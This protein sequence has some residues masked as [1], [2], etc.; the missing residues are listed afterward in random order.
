MSQA[1]TFQEDRWFIS[2]IFLVTAFSLFFAALEESESMTLSKPGE[3]PKFPHNLRPLS[4]LF[5]TA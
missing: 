4:L 5:T 2:R 3:D 1:L